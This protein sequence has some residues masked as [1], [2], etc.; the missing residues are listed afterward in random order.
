VIDYHFCSA[1]V[2]SQCDSPHHDV[3][4]HSKT[5]LDR[6]VAAY[7]LRLCLVAPVKFLEAQ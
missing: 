2:K 7:L 3:G 1:E 5:Y 4:E 6:K